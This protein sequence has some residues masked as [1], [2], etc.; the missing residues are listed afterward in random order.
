MTA[1]AM[2]CAVMAHVSVSPALLAPVAH[3]VLVPRTALVTECVSTG[4][5]HATLATL[6][7]TVPVLIAQRD[8]TDAATALRVHATAARIMLVT[9]VRKR[10][11]STTATTTVTVSMASVSAV[12]GLLV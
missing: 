8:A 2:V 11:V 9:P 3:T 7:S 10:H 5:A 12:L 4:L 1:Q 6:G